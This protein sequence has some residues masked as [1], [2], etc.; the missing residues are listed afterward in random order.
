MKK[1]DAT[2]IVSTMW[3][4]VNT[5]AQTHSNMIYFDTTLIAL[6]CYSAFKAI[7]LLYLKTFL[8]VHEQTDLTN[9]SALSCN[10][11]LIRSD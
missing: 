7:E 10:V 6:D 3:L 9:C 11:H 1:E 5:L 4:T 2:W 8:G